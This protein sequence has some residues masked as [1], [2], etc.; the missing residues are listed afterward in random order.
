M[1]DINKFLNSEETFNKVLNI[2]NQKTDI[3]NIKNGFIAGGSVSNIL[4]H[5]IH[6][7][8]IVINDIDVYEQVKQKENEIFFDKPFMFNGPTVYVNSQNLEL[9]DDNYGN[10]YVSETTG[11][12]YKIVSHS[13]DGIINNIQYDYHVGY[14]NNV[15][16]TTQKEMVILE[17]FDLNCCKSGLDIK[18]NK[19]IYTEDFVEFLT[20]KE[21][22][23]I[24]PCSPLQTTLRMF[25]KVN[26]LNVFCNIEH[27]VRLLTTSFL[28][29]DHYQ[30]N[31]YIGIETKEKYDKY[32]GFIDKYFTLI[33][34]KE[35]NFLPDNLKEYYLNN[36]GNP[37]FKLWSYEPVLNFDIVE[38]FSGIASIMRIWY[39]LYT[40]KKKSQQDKINKIFYKNVFLG[41]MSEDIWYRYEPNG[42]FNWEEVNEKKKIPYYDSMRFTYKML[43]TKKDYYKCNFT[44]KHV[45]I[46][47]KFISEHHALFN[48]I[49]FCD[50]IQEQYN[51]VKYIKS[52]SNKEGDW[53][54]GVLENINYRDTQ[55]NR[56][57]VKLT[58]DYILKE[59]EK[60]KKESF[61]EL[62]EKLDLSDF[63][64]KKYITELNTIEGLRSEGRKM[65]HCVGGYYESIESGE[66]HIF[67][68][69]YEGV[70]STIQIRSPKKHNIVDI[71]PYNDNKKRCTIIYE[72]GHSEVIYT[73][74]IIYTNT[75]HYGRS[76]EKGNLIPNEKNTEIGNELVKFINN[77]CLMEKIKNYLI[78]IEE[79][80]LIFV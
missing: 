30:I 40:T 14:K 16:S 42:V 13:R 2:L 39:L 34:V 80:N 5:L 57:G 24:R 48:L 64:Y 53:V 62:N 29:L 47:D 51:I 26:E 63:K 25:K 61:I 41:D 15:K 37:L 68:I 1:T 50:T 3:N 60:G 59:I 74:D 11:D 67:H 71:K 4:F 54:I 18:N 21:I 19:I 70:G 20:N 7:G 9:I 75:Q 44:I 49:S 46:L 73:N 27:E 78:A 76:P 43:M 52:L 38:G 56:N 23:V 65:G 12:K 58:N 69:E 10:I 35:P 55:L 22:K 36:V 45:D 8:D 33:E 17:G 66:S 77:T 79:K 72:N 6:G 32:L 31:K 28:H